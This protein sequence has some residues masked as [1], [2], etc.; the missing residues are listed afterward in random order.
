MEETLI[1]TNLVHSLTEN[2]VRIKL[3]PKANMQLSHSHIYLYVVQTT[4][5]ADCN[6]EVKWDAMV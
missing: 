4:L 1:Q 3:L 5:N 2:F 6:D